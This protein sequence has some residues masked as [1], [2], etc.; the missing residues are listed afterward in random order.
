[1]AV[2]AAV[3]T[4]R[5]VAFGAGVAIAAI[6]AAAILAS[7]V[8]PGW[9]WPPAGR[10][11]KLYANWLLVVAFD[12]ALVAVVV[13]DVDTWVLPRTVPV[14][15][16]GVALSAAGIATAFRAG[17]VLD[18]EEMLGLPG[19]LHTSGPYA[20]SRH[21]QYVGVIL[22][23]CGVV[24]LANSALVTVL[25]LANAGWLVARAFAEE[26]WLAREFGDAY[27]RYR[28]SVPRFVGRRSFRRR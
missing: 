8:R 19:D 23:L 6:L 12:A 3:P 28:E 26:R 13:L 27:E 11:W 4:L 10:S 2:A 22:A 21:P 20:R 14:L 15:V 9:F 1:M 18:P 24:V 25:C 7:V 5:A 17:R 16:A